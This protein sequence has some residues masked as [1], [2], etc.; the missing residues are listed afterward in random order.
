MSED[1]EENIHCPKKEKEKD[2][3]CKSI[4]MTGF[5]SSKS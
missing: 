1:E 2:L 4:L 3:Q 5:C